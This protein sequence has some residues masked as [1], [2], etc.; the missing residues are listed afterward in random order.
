[1]HILTIAPVRLVNGSGPHE[2]RVE[3]HHNGVWGTVCDDGWEIE[4]ARVVCREL[5]FPGATTSHVGAFFG[6]GNGTIWL[7]DVR[8]RGAETSLSSCSHRSWGSLGSCSHSEDA[9]VVCEGNSCT[10]L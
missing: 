7:D 9:G 6:Q 2:G 10:A 5:G 8:C 3:V 4:D 1:M